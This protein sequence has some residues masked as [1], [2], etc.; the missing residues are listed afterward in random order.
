MTLN[1]LYYFVATCDNG[2]NMTS[3]SKNL[4]V[5]QSAISCAIK[6]LEEE[7][8]VQL[9][10]RGKKVLYL[11]EDGKRFY[12]LASRVI[13][14]ADRLVDTFDLE[15]R[16]S[17][18]LRIGFSTLTSNLFK[19]VL[20]E[21]EREHPYR[22]VRKFILP[23]PKLYDFLR[24]GILQTIVV[25]YSVQDDTH[26]Y[27]VRALGYH[28]CALY[29]HKDHF[30]TGRGKVTAEELAELPVCYFSE[31]EKLLTPDISGVT[32]QFVSGLRLKNIQNVTT[33]LSSVKEFLLENR[34]GAIVASGIR[35]GSEEI[36]EL[37]IEG[38][39]PFCLAAVWKKGQSPSAP[40][41]ELL[42]KMQTFLEEQ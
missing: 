15:Q 26:G 28:Q 34:G 8:H 12:E 5:T 16:E 14:D 27:E 31:N 42:K 13:A 32:E 6:E 23:Q 30:L 10:V 39:K 38:T 9:F 4:F 17:I 36:C 29:V 18:P 35:F 7:F 37:P 1:Q 33:Y 41:E 40:T 24:Q 11:T 21:Y 25:G 19:D 20:E 22:P 3:A 2:N